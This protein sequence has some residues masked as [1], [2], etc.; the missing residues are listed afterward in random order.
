MNDLLPLLNAGI[1]I[2]GAQR[3]PFR[4]PTPSF[5]PATNSLPGCTTQPIQQVP[6]E[7]IIP[8]EDPQRPV[9][10]GDDEG[11]GEGIG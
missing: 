4:V 11:D 2:P 10:L 1:E 5:S 8:D 3:L 6:V 7:C 9:N